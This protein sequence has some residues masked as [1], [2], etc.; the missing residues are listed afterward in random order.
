MAGT[1]TA[2]K[3]GPKAKR[4]AS[5]AIQQKPEPP[6]KRAKSPKG[7]S[8]SRAGQV[9][10]LNK[11]LAENPHISSD[12]FLDRYQVPPEDGFRMQWFCALYLYDFNEENAC[13][14]MGYPHEGGAARSNGKL[15]L[16]HAYCQLKI[17]ETLQTIAAEKIVNGAQVIARLWQEANTPD[18]AFSSNASTRI[19]ALGLLVKILGL[20]NPKPKDTGPKGPAGG[21]MFVPI[22]MDQEE[23]GAYARESQGYLVEN[24]AIDV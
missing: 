1:A 22:A 10:F 9:S 23:W 18:V 6:K 12:Q 19:A 11:V 21:I 14:K 7:Q 2:R 20:A 3:R 15:F 5:R 4:A 17:Q 16:T 8:K 24:A 13:V